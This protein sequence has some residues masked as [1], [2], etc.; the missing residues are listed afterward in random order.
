MGTQ[1]KRFRTI[2]NLKLIESKR[3][4]LQATIDNSKSIESRRRY[5]QFATPYELAREI[6][7]Y[8]LILQGKKD[9]SFLE[10]SLG[11]GAFYS[12]LLAEC[13]KQSKRINSAIGI[14]LDD[15]FFAA[16]QN[17]WGD[18]SINLVNGDFTEINCFE[19]VNFLISNPP[20]VRHHYIAQE[21]K[22]ELSKLT[23]NE[24]GVS[25]SG[26]AGLYCYFILSA[27]KWL[28]P[29][30]I[31]GWL[32]P[33][34]FMDVNYG[35]ALKE[36]LLN[37]VHLLRV[38]RY[39]PESCKFDDALVS[40][41]VVWFRNEVVGENYN[42]EFSFGGT[43]G[44]PEISRIVDKKSL[45]KCK[46]WTHLA[47]KANFSE[48]TRNAHTLTLGDFF[49]IK[50]GLA[51][52]DNDFFILSKEQIEEFD[53]DM[54]FFTP[55]LP[56]PR[57]LKCDEVFSDK[58]GYPCLDTQYFLLSCTLSEDEIKEHH[59]SIWNYLNRGKA[60]T[61]NRYLCKKRKVWYFQEN[62]SVTPFLCSYMG[63]GSSE[64]TI[65]FRFIL[66]HTNAIATNSY[67]MLYPKD[68]LCDAITQSPGILHKVWEAL[69]NITA[70]DLE[71]EG[72]IYG[73]GLKK[74]EPK[75]LACVKC[76][77]LE[78]LLIYAS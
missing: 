7:S 37:N 78:K 21:Q 58:N 11:T 19:K 8:G 61:A 56:S 9:I 42:V 62:R 17:L 36:Y 2:G 59:P 63:R 41:C 77:Q 47:D 66:N 76:P 25:L 68:F 40:S 39:N 18:T 69:T 38:H 13:D 71:C 72:R 10:P 14:E 4:Q 6:I 33:S 74:I 28:A 67:L 24:T 65:P 49:T 30:A 29:N 64:H 55:I 51:T 54:N 31:C 22:A 48:Q 27:H 15:D 45:E 32:I 3:M 12:A 44:K 16:A 35:S 60:T 1:D 5:G 50:R 75:E 53:L 23:R 34:E 20:Y 57:H 52:G 46:K 73:G 43:H 26:L 70:S